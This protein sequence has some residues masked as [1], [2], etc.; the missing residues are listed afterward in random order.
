LPLPRSYLSGDLLQGKTNALDK[1]DVFALGATLYELALGSELPKAG[2]AYQRLRQGKIMMLPTFTTQFVNMLKVGGRGH[3]SSVGL[4]TAVFGLELPSVLVQA[5]AGRWQ[6]R[7]C[8]HNVRRVHSQ[9]P[10]P[11]RH[12]ATPT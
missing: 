2:P 1:A 5:M 7:F 9:L 11:P 6:V 4:A 10:R 12:V 8:T 3:A